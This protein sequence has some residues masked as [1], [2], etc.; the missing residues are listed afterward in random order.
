MCVNL[1]V[2]TQ[3]KSRDYD[4][5]GRPIYLPLDTPILLSC[6]RCYECRKAKANMWAMR[7]MYEAESHKHCTFITLTYDDEHLPDNAEL[8]MRDVQLYMKRLRKRLS[9][10]GTRIRYFCAG[11]YGENGTKRPHYHLI[12]FGISPYHPVFHLKDEKYKSNILYDK[13]KKGYLVYA[14]D[15]SGGY[16]DGISDWHSGHTFISETCQV[17]EKQARYVT[18]YIVKS[19]LQDKLKNVY[20]NKKLVVRKMGT[21]CTMSRR[22]ALGLKTFFDKYF[23][24]GLV[25]NEPLIW[26]NNKKVAMPSIFFKKA[27]ELKDG[28]KEKYIRYFRDKSY[29]VIS[30]FLRSVV[31]IQSARRY[32]NNLVFEEAKIFI[33]SWFSVLSTEFLSLLD[34]N[35]SIRDLLTI[36]NKRFSHN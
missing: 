4:S 5:K 7:I 23:N 26:Y 8:S 1:R 36:F 32:F 13:S 29:A 24:R 22:P 21:F 31:C 34:G 30:S 14:K 18:S 27:C 33:R 28:L 35:F 6:C 19:F 12:I 3:Y 25:D 11:E 2:M 9:K 10:E 20:I 15:K 17:T 16:I